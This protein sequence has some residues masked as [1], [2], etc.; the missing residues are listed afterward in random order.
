MP[1]PKVRLAAI[2]QEDDAR[3]PEQIATRVLSAQAE[4]VSDAAVEAAVNALW[5]NSDYGHT[6]GC[7]DAEFAGVI[8]AVRAAIAAALLKEVEEG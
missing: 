3:F 7:F 8:K 4:C 2:P 1:N 6:R 5:E